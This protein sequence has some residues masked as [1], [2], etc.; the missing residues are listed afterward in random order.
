MEMV[1]EV[2]MTVQFQTLKS[3]V[4]HMLMSTLVSEQTLSGTQKT[5]TQLK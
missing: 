3:T 1:V 5:V 2:T 4:R